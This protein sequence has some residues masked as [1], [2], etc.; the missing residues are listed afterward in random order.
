MQDTG[1]VLNIREMTNIFSVKTKSLILCSICICID[2][3]LLKVQR[4][5]CDILRGVSFLEL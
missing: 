4:Q 2:I 3:T 1:S 5:I